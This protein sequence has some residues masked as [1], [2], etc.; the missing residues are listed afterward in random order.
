MLWWQDRPE[1]EP[2]RVD[3]HAVE[4]VL[5]DVVSGSSP[6]QVGGA[7]LLSGGVT[8]TV[9]EIGALERSLEV[10]TRDLP[11]TVSATD[12]FRS[13]TLGIIVRD[14]EAATR[15][16]PGERPFTVRWRDEF[17]EVHLDRAGDFDRS[18]A[19]SLVRYVDAAC[20][21]PPTG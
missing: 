11:V 5:F 19:R 14:C 15:W 2:V 10:R 17:G 20:A 18:M 8:S 13:V 3:E 9:V 12:R 4:L 1:P 6:L 16:V 7:L 21:N